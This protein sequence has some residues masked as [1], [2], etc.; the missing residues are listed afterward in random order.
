LLIA[1][2]RDNQVE[3]DILRKPTMKVSRLLCLLKSVGDFTFPVFLYTRR[4]RQYWRL[5]NSK[6]CNKRTLL[7]QR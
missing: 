6:L 7:E 4:C 3:T 5:L 2:N 1:L